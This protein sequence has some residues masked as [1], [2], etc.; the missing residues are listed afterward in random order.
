MIVVIIMFVSPSFEGKILATETGPFELTKQESVASR[1]A[2]KPY[3]EGPEGTF[4]AYL[5]L[6][7]SNRTGVHA[8]CGTNPNQ[9]C[10][11]GQFAPCACDATTGDCSKCAHAAFSSVFNVDGIIGLEV[12]TA[13]DASRQG[14]ASVQLLVQTEGPSLSTTRGSTTAVQK[15]METMILP[16]IPL[17]KWSMVT[18]A[19]EGR[20]FD[21]YYNDRIV[22]SQKTMYMPT[23]TSIASNF[24]GLI[25]G[26]PGLSGQLA[27]IQVFS[28]RY[29]SADVVG[30]YK[31][32]SDTRG[33]PYV[34]TLKED[35][36]GL[37]PTASP[38][39]PS[40]DLSSMIPSINL[41]PPGGCF[42]SPV[43]RPAS[44]LYDWTSP[45]A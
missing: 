7:S 11:N 21:V 26:S 4:S 18:V 37:M 2:V 43:I 31:S 16:P 39:A 10:A 42:N 40:I 41:C 36:A 20:R 30:L 14:T 38:N 32:T 13:P 1:E 12:I 24:R 29:S 19:R 3:Y 44:P 34:T 45:Y 23:N 22:L 8:P 15:Y 17:Q 28:K 35:V 27:L 6:G 9:P 25:S 5:F 33:R